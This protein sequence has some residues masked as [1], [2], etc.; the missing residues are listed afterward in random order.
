MSLFQ[1]ADPERYAEAP[2]VQ[3]DPEDFYPHAGENYQGFLVR[4]QFAKDACA[5]CPV[6]D[7]CLDDAMREEADLPHDMRHGIRAGLHPNERARL[8]AGERIEPKPEPVLIPRI[9]THGGARGRPQIE[10]VR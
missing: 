2:C 10:R 4:S 5:E 6:R 1:P 9:E 3:M 8:A 7:K